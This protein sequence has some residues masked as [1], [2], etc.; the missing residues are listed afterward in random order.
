LNVDVRE[1]RAEKERSFRITGFNNLGDFLL[2]LL[3]VLRLLG[4]FLGLEYIVE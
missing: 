2:E 3:G 1:L 4:K